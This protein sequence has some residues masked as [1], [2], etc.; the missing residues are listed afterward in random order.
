VKAIFMPS[1]DQVG[2]PSLE[3]SFVRFVWPLP[4]AFMTKISPAPP[5]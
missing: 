1:G 5:K 4:S 3:A 2:S